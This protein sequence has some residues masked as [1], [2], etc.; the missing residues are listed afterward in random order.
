M[1]PACWRTPG[2]FWHLQPEIV[3]ACDTTCGFSVI[4]GRD[5]IPTPCRR[6]SLQRV[7]AAKRPSSR[8]S[9]VSDSRYSRLL[10]ISEEQGFMLP[11]F[12]LGPYVCSLEVSWC[13]LNLIIPVRSFAAACRWKDRGAT[14]QHLTLRGHYDRLFRF[15]MLWTPQSCQLWLGWSWELFT[16]YLERTWKGVN[17]SRVWDFNDAWVFRPWQSAWVDSTDWQ[18]SGS[19]SDHAGARLVGVFWGWALSNKAT[20]T[21]Y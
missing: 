15:G 9:I 4:F 19:S 18:C 21:S 8:Q 2:G 13:C 6:W 16:S 20:A 12:V 11:L 1:G 3:L 14:W 5:L 7:F 17:G 10:L